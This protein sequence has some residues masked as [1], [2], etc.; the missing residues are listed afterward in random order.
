M[1]FSSCGFQYLLLDGNVECGVWQ[2][3]LYIALAVEILLPLGLVLFTRQVKRRL[4]G[5]WN[6]WGRLPPTWGV[7]D[8][9]LFCDPCS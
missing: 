7:V 3:P 2:T 5:A 9:F 6:V 4:Y 1:W 8:A